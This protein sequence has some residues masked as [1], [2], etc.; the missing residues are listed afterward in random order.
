MTLPHVPVD[1]DVYKAL[2]D[3]CEG[4]GLLVPGAVAEQILRL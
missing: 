3:L 2:H 1:A 4:D